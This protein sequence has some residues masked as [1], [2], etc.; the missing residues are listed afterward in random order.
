MDVFYSR[1]T[2][3]ILERRLRYPFQAAVEAD[4]ITFVCFYG[5][6][7]DASP[8]AI[9]TEMSIVRLLREQGF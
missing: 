9:W 2:D 3:V 1:G 4:D 7:G 5:M 8:S 6:R